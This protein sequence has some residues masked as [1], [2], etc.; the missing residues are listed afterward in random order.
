MNLRREE[1]LEVVPHV[2]ERLLY[3]LEDGNR[4]HDDDELREAVAAVHLEDGLG[5]H[6]GLAGTGFHLDAELRCLPRGNCHGE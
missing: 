1:G 5:I 6:I 2:I 4:R 3:A